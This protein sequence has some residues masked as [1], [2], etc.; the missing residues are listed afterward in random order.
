[1]RHAVIVGAVRTALGAYNGSLAPIAPTALG[2]IVIEAAL[3]RA[4]V[5]KEAVD[6]VIMGQVLPCGCGQNPAKQAAVK[7]Q[8]PWKTECITV[9]KVCGSALKSVML[10]AQA[11]QVG[12]ADIGWRVVWKI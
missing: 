10:A 5:P 7:A 2:G 4:R 3:A 8:M 9:N 11:I 12:D 6:E 1:M